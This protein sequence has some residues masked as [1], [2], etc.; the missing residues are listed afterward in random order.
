[1]H[2]R[3]QHHAI[4]KQ[5]PPT[6]RGFVSN[7]RRFGACFAL[8]TIRRRS[9]SISDYGNMTPAR[10][11]RHARNG[12]RAIAPA[13]R[14]PSAA[15]PIFVCRAANMSRAGSSTPRNWRRQLNDV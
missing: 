15:P 10:Q 12:M 7:L 3:L 9:D 5:K 2:G 8:R 14:A 1:G 6:W 11:D 13:T 4:K